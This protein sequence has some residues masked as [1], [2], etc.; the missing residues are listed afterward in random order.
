MKKS[1]VNYLVILVLFSAFN[2]KAQCLGKPEG[3]ILDFQGS[4]GVDSVIVKDNYA[5]V[6]L[7][8]SAFNNDSTIK[9][10]AKVNITNPENFISY[11]KLLKENNYKY[12]IDDYINQISSIATVYKYG[13]DFSFNES[14]TQ[15]PDFYII[16]VQKD[17]NDQTIIYGYSNSYYS[18]NMSFVWKFNINTHKFSYFKLNNCFIKNTFVKDN[19]LFFLTESVYDKNMYE[20]LAVPINEISN[21]QDYAK[22][23]IYD[24]FSQWTPDNQLPFTNFYIYNDEKNDLY[25]LIFQ[26][27]SIKDEDNNLSSNK[28]KMKIVKLINNNFSFSIVSEKE[29]SFSVL[30]DQI[31]LYSCKYIIVSEFGKVKFLENDNGTLKEISKVSVWEAMKTTINN[32]ILYVANMGANVNAIDISN[33][34]NPYIIDNTTIWGAT[35]DLFYDNEKLY[36][37]H[38]W[39]G[40]A[41]YKTDSCIPKNPNFNYFSECSENLDN[42]SNTTSNSCFTDEDLKK[43][44]SMWYLAGT[45]C[46][47]TDMNM[48]SNVSTVWTWEENHWKVFSN[49]NGISKILEKYNIESIKYIPAKTGFWVK[50]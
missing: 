14:L 49:D 12:S 25:L 41:V 21:D 32:D 1:I 2:L 44:T 38:G 33:P 6:S 36:V 24:Y 27:F 26:S 29:I 23:I 9:G 8:F 20:V 17:E 39:S 3:I 34:L 10:F 19:F 15:Y 13:T 35:Q 31:L 30:I 46:D 37:A 4:Q 45:G 48:F 22:F 28:T 43:I 42:Q 5:Y 50:K 47:I 40:L 18:D 7:N 16:K 11:G